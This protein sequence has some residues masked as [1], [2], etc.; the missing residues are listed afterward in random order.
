IA[1]AIVLAVIAGSLTGTTTAIG[2]MNF[3]ELYDF[4]GTAFLNALKMIIVPL[5]VSTIISSIASFGSGSGLGV[6]GAR[7]VGYYVMTTFLA[8]LVGLVMVNIFTPGIVDGV[9][10]GEVLNLNLSSQEITG[11]LANVEGRGLGDIVGIFERMIPTNVVQAAAET[12]ML[13]VLFFSFIFGLFMTRIDAKHQEALLT[14][15][16]AVAETMMLMT[17]WIMRFAPIGV[18]GLVANT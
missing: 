12:D 17:M 18:F 13:G 6:L 10:L 5:I 8:V 14:F 9:P 3:T 2:P 1:I 11:A 4:L 15:W 7:T 16:K